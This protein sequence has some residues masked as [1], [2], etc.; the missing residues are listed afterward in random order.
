VVTTPAGK[1]IFTSRAQLQP[2]EQNAAGG[3]TIKSGE[4]VEQRGL[5]AP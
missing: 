5:A 1:L 2:V 3:W 4:Q